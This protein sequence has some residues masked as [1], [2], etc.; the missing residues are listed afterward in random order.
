MR[1]KVRYKIPGDNRYLETIVDA[2]SQSQAIKITQAQIPS[3]T[4]IGNPQLL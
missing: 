3:A 1:Y 2:N 4:I